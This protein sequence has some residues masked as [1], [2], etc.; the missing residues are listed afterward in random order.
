MLAA[1]CAWAILRAE[2]VRTRELLA[3]LETAMKAGGEAGV[4]Q[5]AR[6]VI[7]AIERLQAF[8]ET[9]HRPK[10]V[11]MLKTLRGRSSEADGLLDQLD[12]ESEC[13]NGFLAQAKILLERAESGA[14][15][16]AAEADALLRQ[17][18][19]LMSAHLDK[20]DT[21]L[22]SHTALL[23]SPEEWAAV[24]SSISTEVGAAGKRGHRR[25]PVSGQV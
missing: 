4:R 8:E 12:S 24:V 1:E 18:R 3:R 10:G 6:S 23:L 9:T 5:R 2:H 15:G 7:E 11:V 22:H 14:T 13:C 17:H 20:E 19:Q 21:L 16:A 25:S